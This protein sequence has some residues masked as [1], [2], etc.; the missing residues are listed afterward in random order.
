MGQSQ[1]FPAAFTFALAILFCLPVGVNG[2]QIWSRWKRQVPPHEWNPWRSPLERFD[3]FV[4][5]KLNF[6]GEFVK[7]FSIPM[8]LEDTVWDPDWSEYPQWFLRRINCFLG[9]P[10]AMPPIGERR[11]QVNI[12]SFLQS[13]VL[14]RIWHKKW[15]SW[16]SCCYAYRL[17]RGMISH[18]GF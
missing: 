6:Y 1:Y 10:Y 2:Q 4:H 18:K 17:W 14:Y 8:Y 5:A 11:F 13:R 15:W 7:G 9:I 16:W 12:C 3:R